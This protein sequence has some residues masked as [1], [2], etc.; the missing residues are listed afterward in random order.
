ME[1]TE[2]ELKYVINLLANRPL[3]E[4]LQLYLK[5]TQQTLESTVAK[6]PVQLRRPGGD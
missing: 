6:V 1:L 4:S 5:L 3:A 2:Q